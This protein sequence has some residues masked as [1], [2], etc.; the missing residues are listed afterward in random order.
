MEIPNIALIAAGVALFI[1]VIA[2]LLFAMRARRT[3]LTQSDDPNQKPEWMRTTPPAETITATQA[4]MGEVSLYGQDK[5]EQMAA[6]F[7]EQIEDIL[8]TRLKSDVALARLNVDLG[9]SPEGDLEIWVDGVRYTGID[10]IPDKRLQQA[11][12][13]AIQKW[14]QSKS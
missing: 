7:A 13:E 12:R 9:T 14:E 1:I 4:N 5:G 6:P 8:R 2:Y 3:E 11:F 10:A